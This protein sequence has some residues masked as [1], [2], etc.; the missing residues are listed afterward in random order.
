MQSVNFDN[1]SF[2]FVPV[3]TAP[4]CHSQ[5]LEFVDIALNASDGGFRF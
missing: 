3:S 1:N 5:Y 2:Y 4:G